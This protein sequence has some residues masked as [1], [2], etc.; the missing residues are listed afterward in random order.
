MLGEP[1]AVIK[2]R[3]LSVG[4][5]YVQVALDTRYLSVVCEEER[6]GGGRKERRKMLTE[7]EGG[8]GGRTPPL[9]STSNTNTAPDTTADND[10]PAPPTTPQPSTRGAYA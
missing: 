10:N 5:L 6:R 1:V 7:E 8:C 9:P 4:D 3:T 2:P